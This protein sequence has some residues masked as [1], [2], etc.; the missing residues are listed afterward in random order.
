MLMKRF[1]DVLDEEDAEE[2]SNRIADQ[3]E[4]LE[5]RTRELHATRSA[6]G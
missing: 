6:K 5:T 4:A 3:L 1:Q 2:L